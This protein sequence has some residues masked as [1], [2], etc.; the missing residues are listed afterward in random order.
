MK[1]YYLIRAYAN[2]QRNQLLIQSKREKSDRKN[3]LHKKDWGT[4]AVQIHV[5]P[6]PITKKLII[7]QKRIEIE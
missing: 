7:I 3:V 2:L 4:G 5:D 1:H 6:S